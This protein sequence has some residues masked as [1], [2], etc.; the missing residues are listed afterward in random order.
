MW[1]LS[2]HGPVV[3]PIAIL[4]KHASSVVQD[5]SNKRSPSYVKYK[6]R[7]GQF[8]KQRKK[9]KNWNCIENGYKSSLSHLESFGLLP[10]FSKYL[11]WLAIHSPSLSKHFSSI[12][13]QNLVSV[14][15]AKLFWILRM[16][17]S[18]FLKNQ[19]FRSLFKVGIN[20]KSHRA[21]SVWYA[22]GTITS[23]S[24]CSS[25]SWTRWAVCGHTLLCE[26]SI[27]PQVLVIST[28]CALKSSPIW[29]HSCPT[30]LYTF[31]CS[32][33]L[34]G[35]PAPLLPPSYSDVCVGWRSVNLH[36]PNHP[37]FSLYFMYRGYR[38]LVGCVL[39]YGR[40]VLC[41]NCD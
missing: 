19:P 29:S 11:L 32:L 24:R 18:S 4:S 37:Y 12:V 38:A 22:R 16:T 8:C 28:I 35:L 39:T 30:F 15:R 17:S 33:L 7:N 21:R 6:P 14:M 40:C 3:R 25:H 36:L 2:F 10:S 27:V 5:A 20:Q 26:V 9:L 13:L 41:K 1:S 34:Y 31:V 23:M